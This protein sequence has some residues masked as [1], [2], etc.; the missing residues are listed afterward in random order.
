M[1]I[2]VNG[3]AI[4]VRAEALPAILEE[5]GYGGEKVATAVN[6]DFVPVAAREGVMLR[7]G[8][9]LEVVTPRQGG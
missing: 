9:R 5:I 6:E 3:R 7:A 1:R 8:D 4:D 2:V